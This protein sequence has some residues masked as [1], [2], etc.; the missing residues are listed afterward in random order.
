MKNIE[1]KIEKLN[2]AIQQDSDYL[3]NLDT[4]YDVITDQY[5]NG[6]IL[7]PIG[8]YQNRI[9]RE[10]DRVSKRLYRNRVKLDKLLEKYKRC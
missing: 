4:E 6:D 9:K 8:R 10:M 2:I 7:E 5:M 1:K 3:Y